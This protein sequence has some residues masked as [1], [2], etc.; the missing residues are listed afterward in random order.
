VNQAERKA[1][2]GIMI[3]DREYWNKGYGAEVINALLE[4]LFETTNL[5]R[6][7][8]NTLAWNLRAQKCFKKCGFVETGRVERD[9]SEFLI[10]L[11]HR[12]EW[13]AQKAAAAPQA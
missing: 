3:G 13:E 6:I 12:Q 1:E 7:Y 11:L 4:R 9:G 2:I 10:M 8:L 5:D